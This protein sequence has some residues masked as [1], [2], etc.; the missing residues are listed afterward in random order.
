MDSD[1]TPDPSTIGEP[2]CYRH[3]DRITYLRCSECGRPICPD[4][5]FDSAVGQ[6]CAECAKHTGRGRVV[7]ARSI[8]TRTPVV[9]GIIAITVI[10]YFAQISSADFERLLLFDGSAIQ[11]GE[12]WRAVTVALVH[13]RGFIL[14]IAL[15]MYLLYLFGPS[16]ERSVGAA[17]FLG[18]YV[19]S[20]IGGSIFYLISRPLGFAVGASG[21]I[22]GL[23]GAILVGLYQNRRSPAAQ[24]QFRQL[25]VWLGL[26]LALPF[27]VT[28]I[29][30]EAHVGGLVVGAATMLIWQR[31][32]QGEGLTVRRNVIAWGMAVA[33]MMAILIL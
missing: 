13:S 22:F 5:S 7:T 25:L 9:T 28:F 10:A 6:K 30:W 15:N 12:I 8:R 4:C 16:L 24:A 33:G 2:T 31:L 1:V 19:A 21:A 29:A 14:H 18:L 27:F 26:N 32:P 20:A 17:A 11:D 23:W 3:G